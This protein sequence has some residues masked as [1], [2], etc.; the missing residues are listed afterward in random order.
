MILSKGKNN[1][2]N[3]V[4]SYWEWSAPI[5]QTYD[6]L[7]S[8]INELKLE[9]RI[10]KNVY[11]IGMAYNW[12]D[13]NIAD[14]IYNTLESMTPEKRNALPNPKAFLPEGVYLSRWAEI[15]EPFLIEFE[16]GD[17]LAIDYS[18]GSSVRLE[19]NTIPENISFGTNSPTIHADKLFGD[20][21]G[22]EIVSVEVTTSTTMPEFTGSHG[23]DL[24]EQPSYIVGLHILYDDKSCCYPQRSLS[25]N[26][27]MDYGE[28]A[29]K[30]HSGAM[31]KI[32][33]PDIKEVVKGFIEEDVLDSQ[34]ELDLTNFDV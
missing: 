18:E 28:V 8:K 2:K 3:N 16:D 24:D 23:L 25:F 27:W 4:Y 12:T 14:S 7:I 9:G 30:D 33:A 31:L 22:K 5:L 34:E 1:F 10:V 6:E 29:L 15:D 19:M 17:I 13:D 11:C 21:I 32:H 20:I 26:S